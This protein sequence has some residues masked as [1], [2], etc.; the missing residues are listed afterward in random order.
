MVA[1]ALVLALVALK[2]RAPAPKYRQPAAPRSS[3]LA[4][5]PSTATR[6]S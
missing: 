5:P 3:D 6:P 1:G 4:S 2:F